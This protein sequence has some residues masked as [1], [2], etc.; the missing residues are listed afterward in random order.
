MHDHIILIEGKLE[1]QRTWSVEGGNDQSYTWSIEPEKNDESFAFL[2]AANN[3]R[4]RALTDIRYIKINADSIDMLLGW[5]QHFAEDIKK[6]PEL[7]RRMDLVKQIA[8]FHEVPLENAKEIFRRMY[9]KEVQA[10]ETIVTEG[11]KGDCYYVIDSG[12]AEVIRTDPFTEETRRVAILG[13]GDAFGEEAL[14]QDANRNATVT[15]TTPGTLLVLGKDDFDELIKSTMVEEISA[16][17]ALDMV[18]RGE[19]S[20]LDVR[21]DMEYKESRIPGAPLVPLDRL[22]WDVHKLDPEATYIVYCRSGRRSK[23]G[24]YL[25]RERNIKALS[26]KG[27]IKDWPYEVDASP[28]LSN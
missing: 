12:E 11:E 9:S 22:R 25:L 26:M 20:W 23:A 3:I 6:D 7:K 24:T 2:G 1:A 16:D 5:S 13:S 15:M 19:A 18:T 28:V 4:A 27:G 21:Y 17:K 8:I 14:L 10:G